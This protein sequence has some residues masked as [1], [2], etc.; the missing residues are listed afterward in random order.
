MKRLLLSFFTFFLFIGLYGQELEQ[1]RVGRGGFLTTGFERVDSFYYQVGVF[2]DQITVGFGNTTQVI[3]EIGNVKDQ[4]FVVKYDLD[5]NIVWTQAIRFSKDVQSFLFKHHKG[6]LYILGAEKGSSA[7]FHKINRINIDDPEDV[8]FMLSFETDNYFGEYDFTVSDSGDIAVAGTYRSMVKFNFNGQPSEEYTC[9]SEQNVFLARYRYGNNTYSYSHIVQREWGRPGVNDR[10]FN[11]LAFDVN[12]NIHLF[13]YGNGSVQLDGNLGE[14]IGNGTAFQVAYTPENDLLLFRPSKIYAFEKVP[15]IPLPNG[16]KV[17][18]GGLEHIVLDENLEV[19]SSKG[20]SF[21]TGPTFV[22]YTVNEDSY[23]CL[24]KYGSSI[25]NLNINGYKFKAP[26]RDYALLN[27]DFEGNLNWYAYFGG[28][29]QSELAISVNYNE[30]GNLLVCGNTNDN[31]DLDPTR[32]VR[33]YPYQVNRFFLAEYS[34]VCNGLNT[35]LLNSTPLTC[36]ENGLLQFGVNGG[37][38]PYTFYFNNENV[39]QYENVE[40]MDPGLYAAG[41]QDGEGCSKEIYVPVEGPSSDS[42]LPLQLH[43]SSPEFRTGFETQIFYKL[44]N[45]NCIPRSGSVRIV[46]DD[47]IEYLNADPLPVFVEEQVLEFEFNDLIYLDSIFKLIMDVRISQE[48]EFG[49]YLCTRIYVYDETGVEAFNNIFCKEVV[50]SYDPND[51]SVAP[52]GRC[53]ENYFLQDEILEYTIR[54]QNLGNAEAIH[55]VIADTLDSRL[56][57]QSFE[58]TNTS[59]DVKVHIEEDSIL[60]MTF[61]E[62]YL[63]AEEQDEA[64]SNGSFSYRIKL[65]EGQNTGTKIRN[66]AAI[67]F[68]FNDPVIT[69]TVTSTLVDAL[70]EC[71]LTKTKNVLEGKFQLYPNPAYDRLII[72]NDIRTNEEVRVFD[73]SG[74]SYGVPTEYF[75]E[76]TLLDLTGLPSG[77]YFVRVFGEIYR[78][79]K[80]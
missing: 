21:G 56:D 59:H 5:F 24:V 25:Y 41:V 14:A 35:G 32:N 26:T 31:V 27:F 19:V 65:K 28:D 51:I 8:T 11:S 29:S 13:G 16:Y 45:E 40:V 66:R 73:I 63:P 23:T 34:V 62:I 80:N 70:P 17:L 58:Q 42:D 54:F 76:K 72:Q 67:Y 77:I 9:N 55:V 30:N 6:Y 49:T 20:L 71:I 69:N 48:A 61:T 52:Y 38:K 18:N 3:E 68:D 74:R 2:N 50:N 64:G 7:L 1:V 44:E 15:V 46:L 78:F 57:I 36:N 47:Q 4:I 75:H 22:D 60:I 12:D 79:V 37:T 43:Q 39:P 10:V 53:D 33:K